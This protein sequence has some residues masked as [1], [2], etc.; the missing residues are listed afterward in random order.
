MVL[1]FCEFNPKD[2]LPC[3]PSHFTVSVPM[4]LGWQLG[5]R[6]SPCVPSPGCE[7]AAACVQKTYQILEFGAGQPHMHI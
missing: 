1:A 3:L 6:V 5:P 7:V 2:A 4:C